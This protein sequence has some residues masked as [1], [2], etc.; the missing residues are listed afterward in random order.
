MMKM[1]GGHK[2]YKMTGKIG[3]AKYGKMMKAKTGM[4]TEKLKKNYL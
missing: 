3:K 2:A 4:L 1:G